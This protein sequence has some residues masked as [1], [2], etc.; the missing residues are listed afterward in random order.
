MEDSPIEVLLRNSD[1]ENF[2]IQGT[3]ER[4]LHGF[5]KTVREALLEMDVRIASIEDRIEDSHPEYSR[6]VPRPNEEPRQ[7]GGG[8]DDD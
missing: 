5:C 1:I 4:S 8:C 3:H 7:E 6:K 2:D